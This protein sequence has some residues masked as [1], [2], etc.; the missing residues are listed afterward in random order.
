MTTMKLMES[1]KFF[2][3]TNIPIK[4]ILLMEFLTV[5]GYLLALTMNLMV[6]LMMAL[7]PKEF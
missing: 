6:F 7:K 3:K 4:G 1:A 2:S 5:L